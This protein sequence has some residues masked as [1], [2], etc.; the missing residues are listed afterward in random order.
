MNEA[1]RLA[2]LLEDTKPP[3]IIGR[4]RRFIYARA[5]LVLDDL[6]DVVED[7]AGNWTLSKC[8]GSMCDM[9]NFNGVEVRGVEGSSLVIGPGEGGVMLANDPFRELYFLGQQETLT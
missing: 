3:A 7:P 2:I 5:P 8:P 4:G 1:Q 6:G 9:R